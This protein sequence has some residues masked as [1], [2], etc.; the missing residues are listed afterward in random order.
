MNRS[1]R[2]RESENA[3]VVN[4]NMHDKRYPIGKDKEA[5]S[6]NKLIP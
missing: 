1:E 5:Q 6:N 3:P 2:R 4:M